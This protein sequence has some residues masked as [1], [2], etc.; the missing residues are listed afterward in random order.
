MSLAES[1]PYQ[2]VPPKV[3]PPKEAVEK[4]SLK[5]SDAKKDFCC[6]SSVLTSDSLVQILK[7]S[8]V[9]LSPSSRENDVPDR[10]ELSCQLTTRP[11]STVLPDNEPPAIVY[12][13]ADASLRANSSEATARAGERRNLRTMI[14]LA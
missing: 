14:L 13:T 3:I 1:T 2:V 4:G 9:A 12:Y 7:K 5:L 6:L 11:G 8:K 10:F